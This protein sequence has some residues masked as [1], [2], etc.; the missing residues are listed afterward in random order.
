MC[1]IAGIIDYGRRVNDK[2]GALA[3]MMLSIEHR[4][5]DDC[6]FHF[7]SN[8]ALGHRRLSII[9]VADG[10]QPIYNEDGSLCIVFNGEI[11]NHKELKKGLLSRG[12]IFKTHSDT[13]AI[14]HA[15]EDFGEVCLEKLRGMFAIAIW[16]AKKKTLFVA[17]DRLGIKPVY[18]VE[19][20]GVFLFSSEIKA[21]FASGLFSPEVNVPALDSYLTLNY[22]LGPQTAFTGVKKLLPG[23]CLTLDGK[24]LGKRKYWDFNAVRKSGLSF[25]DANEQLGYLLQETVHMHMESEV[26]LG[27][28]LS[29]GVDS[30]LTVALMAK[31]SKK[32]VKTFTVGYEGAPEASELEYARIVADHLKTEHHEFILSPSRFDSAILK[33]L[34]HLDEPIAEY[35][36]IPLM[37]LSELAKGHVTVMLSGEGA[38][39]IFAGYPIYYYMLKFEQ[40]RKMPSL[41]R[42]AGADPILKFLLKNKRGGKYADWLSADLNRRYL[43]NGSRLTPGM[44]DRMYSEEFKKAVSSWDIYKIIDGY[45]A[46]VDSDSALQ[47]MLYL[48]TK[49][50]LPDDLLLKADKMTMAHSL[51]LRVPFLDHVLVEFAAALPQEYKLKGSQTKSIL[52]NLAAG[53]LPERIIKRRKQGFPVPMKQ[54]LQNELYASAREVLTDSRS[55]QRGYFQASYIERLLKSHKK[56]AD[57]MNVNIWSLYSLELWHRL[58]IDSDSEINYRKR[59]LKGASARALKVNI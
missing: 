43:G 45:Y 21:F 25:K 44:K 6:G 29:G 42:S 27:A 52:K 2:E 54:W 41:L 18:Y 20:P 12:H 37:L 4:G 58:F 8:A 26:P 47:K 13:E 33:A 32:P 3:A 1:G 15:Y 36:T 23:E 28:F 14:L 53:F 49:T 22:V 59:F 56:N 34:W 55:R 51:E 31:A 50:W 19:T 57:D 10:K 35:A 46:A 5:L 16:D 30:S 40:Y 11:Y 38:D 17:R 24:G 9:G 48:D 39:E 7:D